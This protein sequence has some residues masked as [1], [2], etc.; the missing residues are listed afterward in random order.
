MGTG[1]ALA[2]F[3]DGFAQEAKDRPEGLTLGIGNYGMQSYRV[4]E[5]IR[6]IADLKYDSLELTVMPEWDSSPHKLTG[7]RRVVVRKMLADTGLTLTS[8]M[9]N[10]VPSPLDADHQKSLERLKLAAEFGNDLSPDSPPLI[11]TVLGGGEWSDKKELFRDR[12]GDWR[13]IAESTK[14]MIA[15]KPHRSGAMSTPEQAAW[16]L[17]QLGSSSR[18]GMIYDYSH[19]AMRG[20]SVAETVKSA[21]PTTVQIVV[22]D[23][24]KNGD[25]F[26]FALP[27][28]ANTFDHAEIL[29]AFYKSGYRRTVCCEVSSQVFRRPGYDA[30]AAAKACY[31]FMN[32]VFMSA[33]IPRT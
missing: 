13:R 23:V 26:E 31:D 24:A 30:A 4:E 32:R 19:Y 22:K 11:Q 16:L 15:I 9:E 10:L 27:G 17:D 21:F 8:L 3:A 5:A 14:T 29:A 28:E 12:L 33:G 1:L 18:M 7:E 25:Q 2:S 20:L 6:L